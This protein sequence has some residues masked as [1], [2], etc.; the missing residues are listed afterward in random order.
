M[1]SLEETKS[2][3]WR[4]PF[5]LGMVLASIARGQ[6]HHSFSGLG[7]AWATLS[8]SSKSG[9]A[10]VCGQMVLWSYFLRDPA[11][12]AH[13]QLFHTKHT[14]TQNLSPVHR[15]PP[16]I[17]Q[18]LSLLTSHFLLLLSLSLSSFSQFSSLSQSKVCCVCQTF[19]CVWQ[20]EGGIEEE[21]ESAGRHNTNFPYKCCA[22]SRI[23]K[24]CRTQVWPILN[25]ITEPWNYQISVFAGQSCQLSSN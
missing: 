21:K 4:V 11:L 6:K 1:A 17:S 23:M 3:R 19:V 2:C 12:S 8:L 14:A 13:H 22:Y 16:I 5:H 18:H 9:P 20:N 15:L 10:P 25:I 24:L 7:T